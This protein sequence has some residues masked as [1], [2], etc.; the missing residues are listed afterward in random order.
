ML[1]ILVWGGSF[2]LLAVMGEPIMRDTGW[3]SQW[4]YG[5]LSLSLMISALL[6]PISSRMVARYG[7]RVQLACSGLIVALG[8]LIVAASETLPVFL[9]AWA[10]I[11]IGMAAGLY[12]ALFSTLG[13]LY[14][15]RAGKAITGITLISGFA[16]TLAWP[17][18]AFAIEHVGW[19]ATCVGYALL[20]V[21]ATP[22][23]LKVLP[24]GGKLR[25]VKGS[26]EQS[27]PPV[28]RRLYLLL[29]WIFALGAII[30]TA[31]SVQLVAVL[32]GLGYSLAAAIALSSLLG[33]SQVA[34]RVLQMIAG[35]R[36]P[37]WTALVSAVL[38]SV[39]VLLVAFA[40]GATAVGLLL[41]GLGNGLRAI[42]RGL[43]PLVLMP[44]SQYVALMGRMSRPSL[45]G[46]ALTPLA[47]GYLMQHFGAL[48]VLI[49]LCSLA[50]INVVLVGLVLTSLQR[51]PA[52]PA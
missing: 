16:T 33:P 14:A 5:A 9:L 29:I 47:S 32:Q 6:A 13:A 50:V 41:Y 28:D 20:L 40:P 30:M 21:L 23:Y 1:Q 7:G 17:L 10:V 35:K 2:F 11:G 46:Q 22:L 52:Q 34:S 4:V 12:E 15:E 31:I 45:I 43:L 42:V 27:S 36:H 26:T 44:A 51:S 25:Q 37:I 39:G 3:G 8:L 49:T 18:V 19:R 48:G 24:S 38:V